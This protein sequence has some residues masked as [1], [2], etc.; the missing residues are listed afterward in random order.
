MNLE[1]TIAA[2]EPPSTFSI[3]NE[4]PYIGGIIVPVNVY[5]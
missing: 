3:T 2:F 4:H 1:E 5:N